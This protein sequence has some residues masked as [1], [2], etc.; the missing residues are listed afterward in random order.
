VQSHTSAP[1]GTYTVTLR[2]VDLSETPERVLAETS[3]EIQVTA[4]SED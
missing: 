1:A 3:F 4:S 2:L